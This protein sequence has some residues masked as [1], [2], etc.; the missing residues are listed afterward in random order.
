MHPSPTRKLLTTAVGCLVVFLSLRLY[1]Y[2]VSPKDFPASKST[3]TLELSS[4]PFECRC[5]PAEHPKGV[6]VLATGDGGWSYWEDNTAKSLSSH[7]Y[8]VIGWDCRKF[9]DSRKFDH[10]K[11]I[12][13]FEAAVRELFQKATRD[14]LPLWYVGWSTG[15]EQSVAAALSQQRPTNL[16]GLVLAAPGSRGRFGLETSDLL[17][18]IPTGPGSFALSDFGQELDGVSVVQIAADLDPLDSTTWL[19]NL[20]VPH[21]LIEMPNTL[22]DMGRAG[23]EFQAILLDAIDWTQ[24]NQPDSK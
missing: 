23:A 8:Y 19:E 13:G 22:H 12:E 17:G 14:D 4:G 10:E 18:V 21:R 3:V 5:Y 24:A 16:V 15:A 2:R 7:G 1:F 11:L 20:E 9:A 6:V